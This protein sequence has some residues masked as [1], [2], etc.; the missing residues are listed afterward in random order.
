[1]AVIRSN[2][3]RAKEKAK[4]NKEI[5]SKMIPV[6]TLISIIINLPILIPPWNVQMMMTGMSSVITQNWSLIIIQLY[7]TTRIHYETTIAFI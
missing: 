6:I 3:K 7:A 5:V 4:E 2:R 1:M